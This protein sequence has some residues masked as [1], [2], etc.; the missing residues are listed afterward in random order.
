VGGDNT[1]TA[2]KAAADRLVLDHDPAVIAYDFAAVDHDPV[3]PF[4]CLLGLA[5]V[6]EPVGELN[7]VRT[8]PA[9]PY[10]RS[11]FVA[12]ASVS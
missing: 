10:H 4:G 5:P 9:R 12:V 8:R 7:V 2:D 1:R 11:P 3:Q 6:L